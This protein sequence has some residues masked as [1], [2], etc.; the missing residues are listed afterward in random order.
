MNQ[1][2][3]DIQDLRTQFLSKLENSDSGM[4]LNELIYFEM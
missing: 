3:K 1:N 2:G 4:I